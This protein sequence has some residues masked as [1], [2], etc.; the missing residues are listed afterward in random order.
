M[1]AQMEYAGMVYLAV[2]F[3]TAIGI[4]VMGMV[5]KYKFDQTKKARETTND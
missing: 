5:D 1:E 4:I 3:I 2:A